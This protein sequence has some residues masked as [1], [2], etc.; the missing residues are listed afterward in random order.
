MGI[1]FCI[2]SVADL[3]GKPFQDIHFIM[4]FKI[5]S[6][7]RLSL[8]QILYALLTSDLTQAILYDHGVKLDRGRID[9]CAYSYE[10]P[11]CRPKLI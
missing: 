10:K 11:R 1:N 4:L 7:N 5:S 2:S 8:L 6:D 3:L 9:L